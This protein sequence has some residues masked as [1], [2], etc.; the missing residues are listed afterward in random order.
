MPGPKALGEPAPIMPLAEVKVGMKG[1]GKTV[2]HGDRIEPFAFEVVSVVSDS[3]AKRG[4]VWVVCTDERMQRSGPV[5]GM[6]GSPMYVWD[7]GQEGVVGEGGRL[8]GA[9]AFGYA[10]VNVCLVGVQPIEYMREVGERAE[11][12][13]LT[14][15]Q[16]RRVMPGMAARSL[17]SLSRVADGLPESATNVSTLKATQRLF[18]G[19]G[20]SPWTPPVSVAAEDRDRVMPL[21]LPLAV[22]DAWTARLLSPLLAPAGIAAVGSD[23]TRVA[24]T[25]PSNVDPETVKLEPGSVLS[26]PLAYGDLDLSAAGTVT[27]VLPDGTVLAFGHAMNAFGSSRLPMATGYTHFVVSR[28]SISFKQAGS[29]DIVGS[30]VRDEASAVAGVEDTA[31]FAAPVSVKIALPAQPERSYNYQ[32]VDDPALTPAILAAVVNGSLTA[33]QGPPLLHTIK[34]TGTLNFT[35]GRT[36]NLDRTIPGGGINGLVFEMLPPTIAMMQNPFDPLQLES[37]D[38][39]VTVDEGVSV[40]LLTDVTLDRPVVQPGDT[41]NVTITSQAFD[42]PT[43]T[44][45]LP[46][47]VPTDLPEGEYAL[48]VNDG[49]TYTYQMLASRPDLNDIDDVDD[50]RNALQAI[51]DVD[52][53]AVYVSIPLPEP[54]LAV[55]GQAM[56]DLPTS[57]AVVLASTASSSLVPFPRFVT[58]H[59][60][61]D[62]VVVGEFALTLWVQQAAP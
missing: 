52:H 59:Y 32:V 4:T 34:V 22:G 55:D 2:F 27:D 6:S 13:D 56:E 57:R 45:T 3:S 43:T 23:L 8:I 54:G 53:R 18:D 36:L 35:D 5:Q 12:E 31:F 16:A 60:T 29:L 19:E 50:L 10:E 51:A 49:P 42:G 48:L 14:R 33:V 11:R 61:A 25:P 24:G 17:A 37:A 15:E 46:F 40:E 30:V 44:R 38:L 21:H 28:D 7:E 20:V 47:A 62:Q 26:I 9:F 41:V 58:K 39:V 1:Y